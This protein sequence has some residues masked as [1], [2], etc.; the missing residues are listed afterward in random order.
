MVGHKVY[1]YYNDGKGR[2]QLFNL[3]NDPYEQHDVT[4]KMPEKIKAMQ[5]T[6]TNWLAET[7]APLPF[8]NPAYRENN[9]GGFDGM[10]TYELSLKIR[11]ASEAKLK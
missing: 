6:L 2:N 11:M 7:D 8:A 3:K 1:H 10:D 5:Q 4:A 9:A